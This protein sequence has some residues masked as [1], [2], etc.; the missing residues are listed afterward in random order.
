MHCVLPDPL[1]LSMQCVLPGPLTLSL[2][3]CSCL[4]ITIA[5]NHDGATAPEQG[6]VLLWTWPCHGPA[7]GK[8]HGSGAGS[9]AGHG[10]VIAMALDQLQ[11]ALQSLNIIAIH[12]RGRADH[13]RAAVA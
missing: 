9:G 12:S 13:H 5:Y 1:T 3:N 4:L 8:S 2:R 6:I 10:L 7:P 11:A